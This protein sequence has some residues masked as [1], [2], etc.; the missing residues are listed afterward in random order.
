MAVYTYWLVGGALKCVG[1][2]DV[3]YT[4]SGWLAFSASATFSAAA[5]F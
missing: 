4:P 3:P 1:R 5:T 2:A